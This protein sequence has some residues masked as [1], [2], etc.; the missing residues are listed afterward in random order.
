METFLDILKYVLPS[1]I[2]FL[3]AFFLVKKFLER[4]YQNQMVAMKA[5]NQKMITPLRLQA[6]ERL[7][8]LM[9]R[10]NLSDLIT[11]THK[12]GMSARMLHSELLKTIRNEFDH[13]IA[14][15]LY[16]TNKSWDSLKTAKEETIKTINIAASHVSDTAPAMELVN[17]LFD[18][19]TKVERLPTEIATDMLKME[20]RQLF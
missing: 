5:E 12:S 3:T 19:I 14:Q 11:R 4:D 7:I 18:I 8:L 9:E 13:N 17:V 2:T 1:V 10:T 15:Q 20:A 16:V 6:Y